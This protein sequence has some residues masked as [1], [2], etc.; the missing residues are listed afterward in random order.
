M[1]RD[2]KLDFAN[3][4]EN[5]TEDYEDSES[6]ENPELNESIEKIKS[7]FKRFL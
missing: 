2:F 1:L 4:N 5:P 3:V 6:M 7:N